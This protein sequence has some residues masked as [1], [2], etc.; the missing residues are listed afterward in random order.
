MKIVV[1]IG[2]T[3]VGKTKLSISLAKKMNAVIM[4][5][6]S[7]QVYKELNIGTAKIKES[8]KEGIKHY[9][10]DI[11]EVGDDYNIYKYQKDGRK[12]LDEFIKN[13][14]NVIIVGGSGLY[15][16][17]LLYDYKFQ[18][19]EINETYDNLTNEEILKE[20]KKYHETSIHVNNRK[21]LVREL[22]K[23]KNSNQVTSDINKK[24]YDFKV[25]GLTCDREKL[26]EV[27]DKR[28]DLMVKEG[29]VEEVKNLYDRNIHSKSIQTGIGY[30]ELYEYFKGNI[31]KDEAIDLIKK[32]TRHFIKR[33][34]T[35][36][37]HQMDVNWVMTDFDNFKNTI[38]EALKIINE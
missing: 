12:L 38:N 33:Q 8:E 3:G 26:Y 36:F 7:M 17:S 5:A 6:D 1:I 30:K 18:E 22:N 34:Y 31:T 29:L 24:L 16:K 15:I 37:K 27:V 23:I 35:F 19:E 11:C 14:Q 25:I 20:I 28:V 9:L 2:P 21:R 10:F 13:N 32:N 4:N